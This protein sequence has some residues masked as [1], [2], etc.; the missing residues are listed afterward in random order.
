MTRLAIRRGAELRSYVYDFI[1]LFSPTL[2][3]ATIAQALR[4]RAGSGE[5]AYSI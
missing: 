2:T 3:Q 4:A 1:E 5:A